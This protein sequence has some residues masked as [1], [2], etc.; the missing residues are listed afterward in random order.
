MV[1]TLVKM[2]NRKEERMPKVKKSSKVGRFRAGEGHKDKLAMRMAAKVR[3][4]LNA[5]PKLGPDII[6]LM[7][8]DELIK[9]MKGLYLVTREK[10]N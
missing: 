7:V 4:N 3:K 8:A 1:P 9:E 6:G 10:K 2:T 5:Y